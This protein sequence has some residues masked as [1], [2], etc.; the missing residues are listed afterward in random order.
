M[1]Y[2]NVYLW[3]DDFNRANKPDITTEA[4]YSVKTGGGTWAI[5]SNTLKNVGASGDPNKLIITGLGDVNVAVDMLV[6]INVDSFNTG[7]ESRMG[8]SCCMDEP[9]SRGSGYC[10]LLHSDTSGPDL[11]NDLRSWGT[12]GTYSWSL[13]T[14]Y[15]MRFRVTDP[16]GRLGQTKVWSVGNTEPSSWTVD[17][18]FGSGVARNYGE[19]G[20]AGSRTTDTTYFDD[21]LIR[22]VVSSEPSTSLGTE[23][24]Y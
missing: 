20:F 18:N 15:Y 14:W 10:A 9:S 19:L 12:S 23:E 17:G 5:E 1:L 6:K 3:Y 11:L 4:A 13:D 8:L 2:H 21:I 24:N 7:D 16:E 22:Y